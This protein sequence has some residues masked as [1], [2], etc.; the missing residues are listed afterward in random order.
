MV[1][2]AA[3]KAAF[4]GQRFLAGGARAVLRSILDGWNEVHV[5]IVE[6]PAL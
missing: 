5:Q 6:Q 1:Y 2:T 3:A 4:K